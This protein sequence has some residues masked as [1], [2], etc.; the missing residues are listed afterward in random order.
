MIMSEL[1][2]TQDDHP[3]ALFLVVFVLISCSDCTGTKGRINEFFDEYKI[4]TRTYE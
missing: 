2:Q 3:D 1:S 4:L